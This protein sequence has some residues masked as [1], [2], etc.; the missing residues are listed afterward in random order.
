LGTMIKDLETGELLADLLFES[1]QVAL[2]E[3][4]AGGKGN[5]HFATSTNRTPRFAQEGRKGT[6]K[7]LKL[8]LKLIADIGIIGL[9]N[10]GKSTLLSRLSGAHPRIAEYPFT[11]L[12][13]HLGVMMLED[14]QSLVLADIPG[15]IKGAS[16]GKGLGHKFLQHIER[17][18]LLLHVLDVH[19]P[20]TGDILG[21]FSTVQRELMLYHP[22]LINKDQVIALNKIDIVPVKDRDLEEI[23]RL[24]IN[25]GHEC[26]AI[27]ALTGE[28]LDELRKMLRR[29][30]LPDQ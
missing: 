26:R 25:K 24:F 1:H 21:D 13:P 15:L 4:G 19:R 17:T 16:S 3:G 30:S 12:T 7:R 22:S 20:H 2:A 9:P 5:K 11:T 27:S 6:E 28:G 18:A 14:N 8:E 29:K 10:A 23:C